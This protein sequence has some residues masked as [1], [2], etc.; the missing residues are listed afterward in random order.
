[1]NRAYSS[2]IGVSGDRPSEERPEV[3]RPCLL[4]I[5]E[6]VQGLGL[7]SSVGRS[8][9]HGQKGEGE[10]PMSQVQHIL[11]PEH[12]ERPENGMRETG[13]DAARVEEK[14]RLER[15]VEELERAL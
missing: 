1:M 3:L 7:N 9:L 13:K 12:S 14:G 5:W 10:S 15:R 2:C 4:S 8:R 6:G 11:T